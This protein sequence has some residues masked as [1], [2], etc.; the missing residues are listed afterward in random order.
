M[1]DLPFKKNKNSRKTANQGAARPAAVPCGCLGRDPHHRAIGPSAPAPQAGLC[2]PQLSPTDPGPGPVNCVAAPPA[3]R[4]G[5]RR[6][7]RARDH[8]NA[9]LGG[10]RKAPPRGKKTSF[11]HFADSCIL[12]FFRTWGGERVSPPPLCPRHNVS[13]PPSPSTALFTY[14]AFLFD[15]QCFLNFSFLSL[16]HF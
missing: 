7:C 15:V 16:T 1:T 8:V 3:A 14:L 2:S 6:H 9:V 12:H 11:H 13:L 5:A 4:H 10:G